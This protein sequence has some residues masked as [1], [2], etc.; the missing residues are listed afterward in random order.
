MKK[1]VIYGTGLIAE[2]AEFY[3]SLDLKCEIAAFTNAS[4]FIKAT[5]FKEK[6]LVPFEDLATSHPPD[7][8]DIFIALGYAKTNQIRQL[9]YEEAKRMGYQCTTY[10]SPRATY[11]G[12]PVGENCLI[13]ENNVIQPFVSIGNNVFLWSGNHIGHH[14][15]IRDHCFISSHV[16]VS[17]GCD[18]GENSFLGVNSTLRDNIKLGKFVVAGAGSVIMKDCAE[19]TLVRPGDSDYRIVTKDLI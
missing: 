13:L 10:I 2:V 17:G 5:Q 16:V 3:F 1:L 9:R 19:R 11:Y 12:T 7:E 4:E 14:S 15:S 18:I 8:Y 6:P